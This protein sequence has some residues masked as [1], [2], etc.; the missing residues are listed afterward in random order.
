VQLLEL[1]QQDSE[2]TFA[3]FARH[4]QV[5]HTT[6]GNDFKELERQGKVEHKDGNWVAT[7]GNGSNMAGG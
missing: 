3:D 7:H 6:I 4:F 2:R 1:W 5:S